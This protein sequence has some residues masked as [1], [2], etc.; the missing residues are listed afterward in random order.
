MAR[1]PKNKA[2][3]PAPIAQQQVAPAPQRQIDVE[4]FIRVRDS[5]SL[6]LV[7]AFYRDA[8][9]QRVQRVA[10]LNDAITV[11]AA[12]TPWSHELWY[13]CAPEL[14]SQQTMS[15]RVRRIMGFVAPSV[16]TSTGLDESCFCMEGR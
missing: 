2:V 16:L 7:S 6:T 8:T 4:Q 5:V 9:T 14:A 3:A 12:L 1:P 10:I 13:A 11:P 15:R